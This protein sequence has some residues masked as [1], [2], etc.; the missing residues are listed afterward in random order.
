MDRERLTQF[1]R[2]MEEL[3]VEMISGYSPQ[4]RGR[5]KRWNGAFQGRLVAEL[6]LGGIDNLAARPTPRITVELTDFLVYSIIYN[7]ARAA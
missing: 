4:A 6:R 3:G 2:A 1:G 7:Q 5:G